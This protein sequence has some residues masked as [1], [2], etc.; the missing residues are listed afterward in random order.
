MTEQGHAEGLEDIGTAVNGARGL[1]LLRQAEKERSE[2]EKSL[3]L[4]VPSWDGSL[5]GEYRL[6]EKDQ[7]RKLTERQL[8]RF[9][10]GDRDTVQSDIELI[11]MA[12]VGLYARD[13]ES[14]DRVS[15]E[16]D[17]GIVTYDRIAKVLGKENEIKS[18]SDAVRYLTAEREENG[19]WE[20]NTIAIGIHAQSI[21]RWM[22]DPSKR[23][24]DLEELLGEL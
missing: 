6:I 16:D 15:I 21:S 10:S 1:S 18:N 20:E 23:S 8:R 24:F 19:V 4:D 11:V 13:P 22:R 2:R 7:L 3:F 14:G 17:F 9:R 12:C 5:I